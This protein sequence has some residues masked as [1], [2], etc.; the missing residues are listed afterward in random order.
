MPIVTDI[1]ER[2][3]KL[4]L[5]LE[6]K[7]SKTYKSSVESARLRLTEDEIV[8]LLLAG[9]PQAVLASISEGLPESVSAEINTGYVAVGNNTAAFLSNHVTVPFTFDIAAPA[10]VAAMA[11]SRLEL[12]TQFNEGQV[13][14]T[15]EAL[16]EGIR[17]GNNPRVTAR[18]I[19]DSIG[20][21][22]R[23]MQAVNNY[24]RALEENNTSVSLN[25][26]LRDRRFDRTV[27]GAASNNRVLS[28]AQ[29]NRMVDR[30]RQRYVNYRAQTIA[31]TESLRA[32]H[33][34]NEQTYAQFIA[35]GRVLKENITVKWV[36]AADRKVRDSH[37]P[38]NGQTKPQGEPFISGN[39][40][41]LR[42]PSDRLAPASETVR[43]RCMLSRRISL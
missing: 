34:A 26:Q 18:Y 37:G 36:T 13:A 28:Q 10:V 39:G 19:R 4:F 9:G 5:A 30:Y 42:Y 22:Q 27:S 8:R 33:E 23:Q 11:G 32:V 41:R 31:Q 43:C 29:I 40:N 16:L 1:A 38:M 24:R 17:R 15:R 7:V 2:L 6:R 20:L 25:R 3:E 14:A 21:T 35:E 12:V